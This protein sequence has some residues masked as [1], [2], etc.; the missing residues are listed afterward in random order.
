MPNNTWLTYTIRILLRWYWIFLLIV[1]SI[2]P[3]RWLMILNYLILQPHQFLFFIF[4]SFT[5]FKYSSSYAFILLEWSSKNYF[6]VLDSSCIIKSYFH[7]DSA[8]NLPI[9]SFAASMNSIS[10]STL[11]FASKISN[12]LI[13]PLNIRISSHSLSISVTCYSLIGEIFSFLFCIATKFNNLYH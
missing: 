10:S 3:P 5:S 9:F 1:K 7:S 4:L 11:F 13:G 6:K 2:P 8:F 12:F